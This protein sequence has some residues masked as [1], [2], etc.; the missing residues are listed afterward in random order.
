MPIVAF[1]DTLFQRR[2]AK[3]I[4]RAPLGVSL[5]IKDEKQFAKRYDTIFKNLFLKYDHKRKKRIYKAAHLVGQL[6]DKSTDF[7][8]DFITGISRY[9]GHIDVYY[10][11]FPKDII[12]RIYTYRDTHPRWYE[13]DPFI[14]LIQNSYVHVC[15]WRYL[16]LHPDCKDYTFH[17]DYFQ[18]K[19][20]PAWEAIRDKENLFLYN[21][22]CEC[23][24]FISSA[25]LVLRH[26]QERLTGA[27][28]RKTVSQ[29]FK[30]IKNGTHV[31]SYWLGPKKEYLNYIAPTKDIDANVRP[32]IK[33]PIFII[34][35]QNPSGR[36]KDKDTFEWSN[37]YSK[38]MEK[39]F[40]NDGCVRFW[41]PTTGPHFVD[42][43]QDC[44]MLANDL[45][46]P[47]VKSIQS[48]FPN[49]KIDESLKQ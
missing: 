45:A 14:N 38:I 44:V 16:Q 25:D 43:K 4:F 22:G 32:K 46:K 19:V 1:D 35:W 27:L 40:E 39:A 17:A 24:C 28:V 49:I 33:H 23:N 41:D 36:A 8:E 21:S 3:G 34:A 5:T 18:G 48:T 9:V 30:N 2:G 7:I 37:T 31:D 26:I 11:Y 15:M 13:P 6:L 12:P 10:S 29:C 20:T 42:E 47:M